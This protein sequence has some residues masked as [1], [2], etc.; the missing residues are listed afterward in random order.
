MITKTA[1]DTD[2]YT[3]ILKNLVIEY[4]SDAG[5][6]EIDYKIITYKGRTYVEIV[7]E[8]DDAVDYIFK[9]IKKTEYKKKLKIQRHNV[10]DHY[11]A[12]FTLN[13]N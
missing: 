8:N 3:E 10:V 1:T 12:I 4:L 13:V 9:D 11:V 5:F 6:E 2:Y 7:F